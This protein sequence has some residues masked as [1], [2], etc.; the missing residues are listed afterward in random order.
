MFFHP[1]CVFQQLFFS[2]FIFCQWSFSRHILDIILTSCVDVDMI[3]A[4]WHQH[5]QVY[6]CH[7]HDIDQMLT[8]TLRY[9]VMTL[10]FFFVI[11]LQGIAHLTHWVWIACYH[12]Q[13]AGLYIANSLKSWPAVPTETM[14]GRI[15]LCENI[16]WESNQPK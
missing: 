16:K 7:N 13:H 5:N 4:I 8:S 12:L 3:Y 15:S 1:K 9:K 11:A 6:W 10:H 14:D 2:Q